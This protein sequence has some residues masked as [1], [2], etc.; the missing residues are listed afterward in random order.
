MKYLLQLRRTITDNKLDVIV[1]VASLLTFIVA[2]L[3]NISRWSVWFDEAYGIY[4]T[5]ASYAEMTALT[6]KDVHPPLY[7]WILKA[8]QGVFGNSELALRS[9][10]LL[11]MVVA[12]VFVYLIVKKLFNT[13]T[14][15]WSLVLMSLTPLLIR[16]SE[17]ARM[18][19][20]AS[21]IVAAA[22]YVLILAT[23]KPSRKK[24]LLYGAL[25]ALGM[26]THYFT[27]I[28]WIA[29]WVWRFGTVRTNKWQETLRRFFSP[30]WVIAHIAA[31]L[32]FVPWLPWM[33]RQMAG[34]QGSGFW[35]GPVTISTPIGFLT[36]VMMY[37]DNDETA[38][39][40]ALIGMIIIGAGVYLALRTYPRLSQPHKQAYK[41]LLTMAFVP[42]IVLLILS[43][44]PFRPAF[45]DRYLLPS[46]P[47]W[48]AAYGVILA[49]S[50]RINTLKRLTGIISVVIVTTMLVGIG[51]V[52]QIGNYN[53]TSHDLLPIKST[54]QDI[55]Q[56]ATPDE[57]IVAATIWRFYESHYYDSV[58]NPVY[59]IAADNLTW[60]SYDPLRD[61]DYRKVTDVVDFA[62]KHGGT[63]WYVDDWAVEGQ[64]SLPKVGNWKVLREMQAA[65]VPNNRTAL[66]A[67]EIQLE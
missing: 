33:I 64:P 45:V 60:G 25:V 27:A 26:W 30:G 62:R 1:G 58:R 12:I 36:D 19:G 14:A 20:L 16:Y 13:R 29:H 43:M 51:Y 48:C 21:A 54:M 23:E 10:S 9:L 7:Y 32:L 41:F 17:E 4:I 50:Y 38:G 35:I 55:Q 39:W 65:N 34:V 6:A 2:S 22:S 67:V 24:W 52:Y 31:L 42:M 49:Q 18:Y 28:M 5:R 59:F 47:F 8:W 44:P 63:I 61:S 66:R 40:P 15:T 56:L 46:V 57:P 11:G 37:R 3:G 53:K